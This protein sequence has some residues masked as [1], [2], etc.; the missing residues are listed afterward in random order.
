MAKYTNEFEAFWKLYPGRTRHGRIRKQDKLGAF[1]EW[2]KMMATEH[3]LAMTGHP[4]QGEFTPDARKWLKWKRWQDEDVT[5]RIAE[6]KLLRAKHKQRET[7]GQWI[8]KQTEEALREFISRRPG[9][10]WLVK[11]LRPE[12]YEAVKGGE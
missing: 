3:K 4:E 11:E 1:V 10:T 12:I 8:L 2:C 9:Y 6:H 5:E 7:A